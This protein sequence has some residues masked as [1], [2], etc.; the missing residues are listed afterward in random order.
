[1]PSKPLKTAEFVALLS[2]ITSLT[3][4]SIDAMLPALRTIGTDLQVAHANNTQLIVSL[5]IFGMVFGELIFGPLSDAIGRK[6]AILIGLAIYATG[7]VMAMTANSLELLLI[8]R[9]VQGIGVSGPKIASR[10]LVR[11]QFEGAEMAR[12]LSF[13]FMV[14][15]LVPMLAP[16]IGQLIL[17]VASWRAIFFLYLGFSIVI[18]LWLTLRQPETLLRAQRISL[19]FPTLLMNAAQIVR[20]RQVMAYTLAAGLIFGAQLLYLGTAQAIFHDLY[21][22]DETFPFYFALLAFGIGLSAFFNSQLV[23][24]FGM[25]RLTL[26]ALSGLIGFGS[27]LAAAGIADAGIPPFPLFIALCF[28][29]FCCV[30][31]LFGN[32]NAMAMQSLGRVAG[33]GASLIASLS[34][35]LAVALAIPIGSLYDKS[36]LPLGFGFALAGCLALALV[37]LAHR[38][39]ATDV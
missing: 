2:L 32:L 36:V 20:H 22:I 17:Q 38:S 21:A 37:L 29:L 5:F 11:D 25:H 33:L 9:V 35:L 4:V 16:G 6:S 24:R 23:M 30:G 19:S 34:S 14:F 27:L 26:I 12:I 8:G 31:A 1:M 15:I 18:A 13:I 7:T 28:G 3:A 10:A 39:P